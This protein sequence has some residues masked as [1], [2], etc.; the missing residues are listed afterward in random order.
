M[1]IRSPFVPYATL[2]DLI[3]LPR[4]DLDDLAHRCGL[5]ADGS[6]ITV[7]ERILDYRHARDPE[8]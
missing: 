4:H 2:H 7:A 1:K 3:M 8:A 6:T 5:P